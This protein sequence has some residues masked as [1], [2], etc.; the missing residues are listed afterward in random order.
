LINNTFYSDKRGHLSSQITA[1][2]LPR[3]DRRKNQ[4][5][6]LRIYTRKERFCWGI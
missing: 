5:L 6:F 4:I 2:I 1:R 3:R